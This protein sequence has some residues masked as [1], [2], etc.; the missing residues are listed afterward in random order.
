MELSTYDLLPLDVQALDIPHRRYS[1]TKENRV[2]EMPV[3]G[4]I[5]C[6][7]KVWDW[8]LA[9]RT[10]WPLE[11]TEGL[12]RRICHGSP[13]HEV[14]VAHREQCLSAVERNECLKLGNV[15]IHLRSKRI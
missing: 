6:L 4:E 7:M 13:S 9:K 12:S 3:L 1:P 2:V 14:P 10:A 15:S 8:V 11:M 5:A